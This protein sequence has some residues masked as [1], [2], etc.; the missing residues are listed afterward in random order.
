[1]TS[2]PKLFP[3]AQKCWVPDP[4]RTIASHTPPLEAPSPSPAQGPRALLGSI[5]NRTV[6]AREPGAICLIIL[7]FLLG[8][9]WGKA[10]VAEHPRLV[11]AERLIQEPTQTPFNIDEL[12]VKRPVAA[13]RFDQP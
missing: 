6:L 2:V 4:S 7:I 9:C 8:G 12:T 11:S 3:A 10:T 1:M 13:I 5:P